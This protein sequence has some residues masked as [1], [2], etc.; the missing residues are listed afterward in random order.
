MYRLATIAIPTN[1]PCMR[2]DREPTVFMF[3]PTAD[4]YLADAVAQ[5]NAA[6]QPVL[7]GTG[8]VEESEKLLQVLQYWWGL[9]I[10]FL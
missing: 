4:R 1:K 3:R 7:I 8:T 10:F 9:R 6:N 5:A 2:T